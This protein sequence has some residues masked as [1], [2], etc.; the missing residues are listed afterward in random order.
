MAIK[1]KDLSSDI[2][3]TGNTLQN[4]NQAQ[5]SQVVDLDINDLP[6]NIH[7]DDLKKLSGAKHVIS[8]NID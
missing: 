3:C 4:F 2:L 8:V 6:P 7:E 1:I 5:H